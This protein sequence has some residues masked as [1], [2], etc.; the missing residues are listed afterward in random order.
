MLEPLIDR[1]NVVFTYFFLY[2]FT[3]IMINICHYY[4]YIFAIVCTTCPLLLLIWVHEKH[5]FAIDLPCVSTLK[6]YHLWFVLNF[7]HCI[8]WD[9]TIW[10]EEVLVVY[11]HLIFL[12]THNYGQIQSEMGLLCT[13]NHNRFH[14]L[15]FFVHSQ[16]FDI[17][18]LQAFCASTTIDRFHLQYFVMY[19]QP[20][21]DSIY[22]VLLCLHSHW[23]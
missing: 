11:L 2:I 12:C 3:W 6:C 10:S 18:H 13:R 4:I 23:R 1:I 22:D 14:V 20:Y 19:S 15:H 16:P 5:D 21:A 7:L 17:F 9:G 8:A